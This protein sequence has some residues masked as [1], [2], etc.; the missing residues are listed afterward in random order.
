MKSEK[1]YNNS[2]VVREVSEKVLSSE[3]REDLWAIILAVIIMLCSIA[4]P[5]LVHNLFKK[6]LFFF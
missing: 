1:K 5:D 4:A 2:D 6:G 3:K